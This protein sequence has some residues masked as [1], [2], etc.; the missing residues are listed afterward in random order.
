MKYTWH[1]QLVLVIFLFSLNEILHSQTLS[2][3]SINSAAVSFSQP[4]GRLSFT[5]GE[6][7]VL[8]SIDSDGN[9]LG[10]G[11]TNGAVISVVNTT[12]LKVAEG[13]DVQVELFPNPTTD[14][15]TLSIKSEKLGDFCIEIFDSQGKLI[16]NDN[17]SSFAKNIGVNT[18]NWSAGI[19][20]LIMKEAKG[21]TLA[22]FKIVKN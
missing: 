13:S 2:P 11:F 10:S 18:S 21:T 4:N 8:S 3:Q 22:N 20:F 15:L 5:I 9:Q 19:Y 7:V 1:I 14:L 6:L 12:P 16:A 17:Y